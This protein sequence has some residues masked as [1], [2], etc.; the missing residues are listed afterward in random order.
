MKVKRQ[1]CVTLSGAAAFALMSVAAH[2]QVGSGWSSTSVSY[3][4]QQ[5]GCGQISG[6]TFSLTCS[7]TS[8]EQRAERRYQTLSSGQRQFEGYVRISSSVG[9][10]SVRARC[11]ASPTAA[12]TAITSCP[13]T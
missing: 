5:A 6:G 4:T 7:N 2:A 11:T 9:I 8:G 12:R 1:V 13:S 10:D 3:T